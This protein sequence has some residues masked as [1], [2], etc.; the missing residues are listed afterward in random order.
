MT[1]SAGTADLSVEQYQKLETAGN[2][3]DTKD[4]AIVD[5]PTKIDGGTVT[6]A[7]AVRSRRW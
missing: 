2:L 6:F 7:D 3:A 5:D 1:V 4:F